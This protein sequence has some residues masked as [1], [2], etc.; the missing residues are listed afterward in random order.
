MNEPTTPAPAGPPEV[1]HPALAAALSEIR[2]LE[3]QPLSEHHERLQSVHDTMHAVLNP[4][5]S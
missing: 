4:T 3:D 2:D 1:D 5:A